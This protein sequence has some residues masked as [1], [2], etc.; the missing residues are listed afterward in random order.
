MRIERYI[1]N[2]MAL[3]VFYYVLI[4]NYGPVASIGRSA[5]YFLTR[6]LRERA[7]EDR[8]EMSVAPHTP[9]KSFA[10]DAPQRADTHVARGAAL[11]AIH[12]ARVGRARPIPVTQ[13]AESRFDNL[14]DRSRVGSSAPCEPLSSRSVVPLA[15]GLG[16]RATERAANA[17]PDGRHGEPQIAQLTPHQADANARARWKQARRSIEAGDRCQLCR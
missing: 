11:A 10:V 5:D 14:S 7:V 16:R 4:R 15:S 9:F 8:A 1:C 3:Y 12:H 13:R 17:K 2:N 6:S